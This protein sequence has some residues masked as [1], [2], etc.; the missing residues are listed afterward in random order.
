MDDA[1]VQLGERSHIGEGLSQRQ[2][3]GSGPYIVG[4]PIDLGAIDN[5][6]SRIKLSLE[7]LHKTSTKTKNQQQHIELQE[8]ATNRSPTRNITGGTC[9]SS[10][11]TLLIFIRTTFQ[12]TLLCFSYF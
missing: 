12:S 2:N 4:S 1:L 6:D 3:A 9:E 11:N 5:V 8:T 10:F 7:R